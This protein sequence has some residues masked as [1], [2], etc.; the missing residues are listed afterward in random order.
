MAWSTPA[1]FAV[2]ELVTAAKLNIMKD[3]LIYLKGQVGTV[4]IEASATFGSSP[5][6]VLDQNSGIQLESNTFR[7]IMLSKLAVDGTLVTVI[8]NAT[9]D[10][11]AFLGFFSSTKASDTSVQTLT[12]TLNISGTATV[13]TAG[14]GTNVCTLAVAADGS[15]TLQRTAGALTYDVYLY[16]MWR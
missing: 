6:R 14:G 11:T 5:L 15:V 1:A 9:G 4:A 8:P 16:L 2:A 13:Y 7:V 10:V 3:D 12:A